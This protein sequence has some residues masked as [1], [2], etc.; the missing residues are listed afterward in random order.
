MNSIAVYPVAPVTKRGACWRTWL[1][2][3]LVAALS[4]GCRSAGSAPSPFTGRN[5]VAS[6]CHCEAPVVAE[7]ATFVPIGSL[8][9]AAR[10]GE[11]VIRVYG[12]EFDHGSFEIM[13][14]GVRVYAANGGRFSIGKHTYYD[15]PAVGTD[16][17]GDGQ[18]DL[19]VHEWTGGAHCCYFFHVFE[20]GPH[21]RF[22]QTIDAEHS[23]D[24]GFKQ[25]D[26]DPALEF[27]MVDWTFAY[28][29]CCFTDSPAPAVILKYRGNKFEMAGE[30]MRK[31]GWSPATF[32]QKVADYQVAYPVAGWPFCQDLVDLIYSGNMAQ[33]W[34]LVERAWPAEG[35]GQAKFL[36]EFKAQLHTS[37]YWPAVWRM[38]RASA[39]P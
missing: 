29:H 20:I 35:P 36:A 26:A 17:T 21:F 16:L 37:P 10:C 31:P 4:G 24:A 14:Q 19:V 8:Q 2:V 38:N 22:I 1:L 12:N 33:A 13:R 34:E 18:P 28:W 3:M 11:Y 6:G 25:L 39:A 27:E 5:T 9:Q 32:A 15:L 7:F 23:E 30:L